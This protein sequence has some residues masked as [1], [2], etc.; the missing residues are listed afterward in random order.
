[1]AAVA[2]LMAGLVGVSLS[3]PLCKSKQPKLG[4]NNRCVG[5]KLRWSLPCIFLSGRTPWA[6][7][8]RLRHPRRCLS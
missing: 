8:E 1:L 3:F 5:Y 2:G 7:G 4:V 6:A